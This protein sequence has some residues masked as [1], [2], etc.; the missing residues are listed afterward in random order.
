MTTYGAS[1]IKPKRQRRTRAEM[2]GVREAIYRLL[3]AENPM[4]VR[5]CFYRL[6]SQGVI[7]K[8]EQE[9][10][11]TVVRS[12]TAMRKDGI[13]P[14][15][16]ICDSAR[17]VRRLQTYGSMEEMLRTT[18]ECYRRALWHSQPAYVEFWCEKDALGGLILEETIKWD[19][20]LMI[21][22][23]Y[24]SHTFLN[25]VAEDLKVQG[26]PCLVYMLSDW[27]PSGV[28]LARFVQRTLRDYAPDAD[29]TFERIAVTPEQIE[30][31]QLPTR[32][33]K[34]SDSRA[35]NFEG[36]SVDLDAIPPADLKQL[37]REHIEKHIDRGA[38]QG[39]LDTERVERET[40]DIIIGQLNN[41][42]Y[43]GE[44]R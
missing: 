32:P 2:E 21:A 34:T 16:W 5:Q 22:R 15:S 1:Y 10:N 28:D 26:K 25:A 4:T 6:V 35:K 12:L 44:L 17:L 41:A 7:R 33:T 42:G 29:I 30:Q 11:G 27:D 38:L 31:W 20:P 39:E 3:Q 14:W 37:V 19:V 9:Y 40:L 13:V 43:F 23:G 8:T 36:S 24:S 18:A